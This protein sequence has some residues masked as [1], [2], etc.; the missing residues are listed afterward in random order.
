MHSPVRLSIMAAL[1]AAERAEFAFVRDG[2]EVSDSA[3][4]KQVSILEDAGYVKVEKGAIG[5]RP[6]TWLSLTAAGQRAFEAHLATLEAIASRAHQGGDE[7]TR[8]A[9][10]SRVRGDA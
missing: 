10:T 4:S 1:M 7:R 2:V 5:R 6:R 8:S 3:L 9:E